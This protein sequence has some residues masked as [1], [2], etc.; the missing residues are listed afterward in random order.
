MS[1]PRLAAVPV[2]EN[3]E[4]LIDLAADDRFRV[5]TS[6][7]FVNALSPSISKVRSSVA[8]R[9]LVAE[10]YLPTGI[11]ILLR[12]GHRPVSVQQF[13]FDRYSRKLQAS[14]PNLSGEQLYQE[15][16]KFVAPPSLA[17]HSTG[18]AVDVTLIE[19]TSGQE[20]DM[21]SPFNGDP[22][23]TQGAT[24]TYAKN[25]KPVAVSN[26]RVLIDAMREAGFINY[27]TEWWHWSFGDRY[28]ALLSAHAAAVYG[29]VEAG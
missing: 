23:A 3:G 29:S 1:D 9:L 13:L 24:F 28:W 25:I 8:E 17:P 19:L 10:R 4:S 7:A 26:R 11:A 21:G 20:L 5:D 18:G 27:P 2:R 6:R 16:S 22:V 14:Q 15:V 12:E